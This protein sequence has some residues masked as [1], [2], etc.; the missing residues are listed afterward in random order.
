M[1]TAMKDFLPELHSMHRM[2]C[3]PLVDKLLLLEKIARDQ[4]LQVHQQPWQK[5]SD[6]LCFVIWHLVQTYPQE[7][8]PEVRLRLVLAVRITCQGNRL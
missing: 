6:S 8:A 1:P 3:A 4:K 7:F 2:D 5:L